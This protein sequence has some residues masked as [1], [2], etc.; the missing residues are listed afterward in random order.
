[1]AGSLKD[2]LLNIG[3][4]D[5][6]KAKKADSEKKKQKKQANKARKSGQAVVDEKAAK[7]QA[8]EQQRKEKQ[9]RDRLL[10][11]QRDE[12]RQNREIEAQCRQMIMQQQIN[13]PDN[14]ELTYNFVYD[15]KVKTMYVTSDLQAQLIR[16]Q[17]AIATLDE[18]FY[19]IPDK[20]AEKIEQRIP[21]Y[22]IRVQPE[23]EPDEDDP[24][25]DYKIPDDLMW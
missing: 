22:V 10:N 3:L 7:Q 21:D 1:M 14:A 9:E 4:V 17:V 15:K 16:G 24:Y 6:K 23:E 18:K 12:E 2:Q 25:A 13:L 20:F 8:L 11:L 5:Q 19:L